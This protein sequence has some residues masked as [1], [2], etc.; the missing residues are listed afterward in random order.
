MQ[1]KT[2]FLV[3][4]GAA[5]AV[6]AHVPLR[7]DVGLGGAD[8]QVMRELAELLEPHT[9]QRGDHM[10][11]GHLDVASTQ[12]QSRPLQHVENRVPIAVGVL[13]GARRADA[14]VHLPCPCREVAQPRGHVERRRLVAVHH[15]LEL[16]G[17]S[18]DGADRRQEPVFFG[19]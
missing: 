18:R 1:K 16:G 4:T 17:A 2:L 8:V 5:G 9:R 10:R 12:E 14:V 3:A 6:L 19:R 15:P 7:L 13:E 11:G